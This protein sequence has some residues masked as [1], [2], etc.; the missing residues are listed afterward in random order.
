MRRKPNR[1]KA[2]LEITG[3]TIDDVARASGY[4]R[5]NVWH[6]IHGH[7]CNSEIRKIICNLTGKAEDNLWPDKVNK[8]KDIY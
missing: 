2:L 8:P 7:T 5:G 6:V 3:Y 4:T 1:I